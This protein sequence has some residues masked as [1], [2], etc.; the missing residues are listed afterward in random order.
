[1]QKEQLLNLLDNDA[2][3]AFER[4]KTIA[5]QRGGVLSPLHLIA[6]LLESISLD[7]EHAHNE[8]ARALDCLHKSL[9]TRHPEGAEDIRVTRET[10]AAISEASRIAKSEGCV[11]ASS[12]HLLRA[13]LD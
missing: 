2:R 13:A 1:M 11:F 5:R 3:Q 9:S 8:R 12:V 10:Q 7:S 6:A 4:A